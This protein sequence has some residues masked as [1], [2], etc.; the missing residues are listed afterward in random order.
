MYNVHVC[1]C[2]CAC[3]SAL[4]VCI[5]RTVYNAVIISILLYGAETWTLKGPDVCRLTVF[6]NCCVHTILG[7]SWFGQWK[8]R[9]TS[10]HLSVQFGMPWSIADYILERR[11]RWLGHLGRMD[12][13]RAPKQLLFGELVKRR[14]FQGPK[15]RWRDE[16][17]SDLHA[18]GVTDEWH[19]L[20]QDRR[21]W[22]ELC[23]TCC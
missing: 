13:Q 16:V 15:K 5:K 11:L 22:S 23:S 9:F 20:C 6:H 12:E 17:M 2:V 21:L 7:V 4:S 1:A 19:W 8:E 3:V 14:P 18:L 10:Q